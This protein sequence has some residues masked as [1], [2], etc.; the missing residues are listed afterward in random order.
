MCV[1]ELCIPPVSGAVFVA[2]VGCMGSQLNRRTPLNVSS[3]SLLRASV[4]WVVGA[5]IYQVPH[6]STR[7]QKGVLSGVLQ[8]SLKTLSRIL[9]IV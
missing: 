2:I 6:L 5:Y 7:G 4:G 3:Y 8:I 1:I 9:V